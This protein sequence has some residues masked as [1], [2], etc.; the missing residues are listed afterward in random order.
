MTTN[1]KNFIAATSLIIG[2]GTG[3]AQAAGI[4]VSN[5]GTV[6]S[7]QECLDLAKIA[8]EDYVAEY[9]GELTNGSVNSRDGWAYYGWDLSPA[10]SDAVIACPIV[11]GVVAA[12]LTVHNVRDGG[13]QYTSKVADRINEIWGFYEF[14]L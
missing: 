12:V 6:E 1:L 5:L 11:D 2:L 9:G 3:H 7:V 4:T 10:R 14:F 8:L 13:S